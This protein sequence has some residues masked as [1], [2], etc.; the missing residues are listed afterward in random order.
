MNVRAH[1]ISVRLAGRLIL[2]GID[3]TAR[4]GEVTIIIG[5][6]GSGKTTL[7]RA[8]TGELAC[9]GN[10]SINGRWLRHYRH[11][12]LAAL[13]AVL[14][15][16]TTLAFPFTVR[17]IVQMGISSASHAAGG[18][19]ARERIDE[20]LSRVDLAGFAGRFYQE[21]SGG[22]RQRV[23]LARVLCQIWEPQIA[24]KPRWLFLDEP[25][26]SLD[27][28]HQIAIMDIARDYA[29]AGGGVI[30]VMHDLNLSVMY[31]DAIVAISGGQIAAAG[32]P[33]DV[34]TEALLS[35]VFGCALKPGQTPAD[36]MFVLPHSARI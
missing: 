18:R 14:P 31:A 3:F 25:V 12:D 11:A 34:L 8:L 29:A 10:V 30:A 5:P 27:I 6:N 33:A 21:L 15:Q 26:S 32:P 9:S 35:D 16:E 23:Q 36:R 2:C 4:A 20:A 22:E 24:G 28:R 19:R 1:D 7:M 13:R 17:E